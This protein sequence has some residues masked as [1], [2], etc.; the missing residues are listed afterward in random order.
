MQMKIFS[1]EYQFN[2]KAFSL[3]RV[4]LTA[5]FSPT[6]LLLVI[7]ISI[8]LEQVHHGQALEVE[9][10]RQKVLQCAYEAHPR[11]LD[12]RQRRCGSTHPHPM[13]GRYEPD[14]SHSPIVP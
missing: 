4:I 6:T 12:L 5:G 14:G 8:V 3:S 1:M 13:K 11:G 10:L 9:Q 7:T 2:H